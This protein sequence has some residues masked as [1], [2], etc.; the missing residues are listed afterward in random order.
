MK[1]EAMGNYEKIYGSYWN[2]VDV[3]ITNLIMNHISYEDKILEAGFGSGHYLA[4]LSD[5]GYKVSG[6]EIRFQTFKKTKELFEGIYD[7][8]QL[9]NEDIF[10]INE[11]YSLIYSTGLIQCLDE[12]K[13]VKFMKHVASISNKVVYTVPQIIS[14]RNVGSNINPGVQ[15]C[16]EFET[17]NI[18]Y[19]LSGIYKYVET[20]TWNKEDINLTENFLWFYCDEKRNELYG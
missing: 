9:F 2:P 13:R 6:T 14:R 1:V 10:N 4:F 20:G 7:S 8:V 19:E 18:A 12:D 17:G 11:T 15:G 3:K 16:I 5:R